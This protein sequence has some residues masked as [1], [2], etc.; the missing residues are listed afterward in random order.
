MHKISTIALKL[1]LTEQTVRKWIKQ[2]RIKVVRLPNGDLR[3][4]DKELDR[5]LEGVAVK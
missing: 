3:V 4:S 5:L 1:D 2:G